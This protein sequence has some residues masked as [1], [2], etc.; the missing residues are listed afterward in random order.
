MTSKFFGTDDYSPLWPL[1]FYTLSFL[2]SFRKPFISPLQDSKAFFVVGCGH[3]GTSLLASRLGNHE[4]ILFIGRESRI[5][6]PE[7]NPKIG[8]VIFQEWAFL[9]KQ[10]GKQYILEKT[11]KHIHSFDYIKK[12]IPHAK[13]LLM[14]RNPFDNCA[15]LYKRY[16]KLNNC[17]SRWQTDNYAVQKL[18]STPDCLQVKYENLTSAPIQSFKSIA[19]FLE[20]PF[21]ENIVNAQKTAYEKV[22]L[23][24][25]MELRKK[26]VQEKISPKIGKFR[27]VFSDE[28]IAKVNKDTSEIAKAIGY[29][30]TT[31]LNEF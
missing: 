1:K 16:P 6:M 5:F 7:Q 15:S 14:T 22:K 29:D 12:L 20:I 10:L 24:E 23:N 28:Q 27:T 30:N 25:N 13:F 26:Q 8:K 31:F 3:S 18:L 11:P 4:A 21:E 17:I 19:S 9:A 2:N